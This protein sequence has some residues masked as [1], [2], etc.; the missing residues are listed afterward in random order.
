MTEKTTPTIGTA[1]V[2]ADEH[3]EQQKRFLTRIKRAVRRKTNGGV[4]SLT[5]EMHAEIVLI[6][7]RCTSFYCK[8]M[9]QQTAMKYLAE[10]AQLQ[11]EIE[12]ASLPR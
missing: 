6:R 10:G 2:A 1:P 3:I 11:N 9:A 5:V 7:G 8:Q 4:Q 12:V